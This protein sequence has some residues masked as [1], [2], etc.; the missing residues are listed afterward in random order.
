MNKATY[1][2]DPGILYDM[3]FSLKLRFNGERA[4]LPLRTGSLTYEE[5]EKFYRKI[6]NR[7]SDISDSLFPFFYYDNENDIKTAMFSY[8]HDY[9]DLT[10]DR[11]METF[12]ESLRDV[13]RLKRVVYQNYISPQCP[14]RF[15][16]SSLSAVKK[17][18]FSSSL[19]DHFKIHLY[20]FLIFGEDRIE[21]IIDSL[22][23]VEQLCMEYH[24][25]HEKELQYYSE[26]F[27]NE[28]IKILS[29]RFD[30]DITCFEKV[31][32]SFCSV[33]INGCQYVTYDN[34]WLNLVGSHILPNLYD[35]IFNVP[36]DLFQLGTILSDTQRLKILDMLTKED[37]YCA[38]I[39]RKLGIKNNSTLYH[40]FMMENEGILTAEKKSNSKKRIYYSINRRYIR[41][42][43]KILDDTF[44]G[45]K[46]NGKN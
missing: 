18:I 35:S 32:F 46:S 14:E 8:V 34:N 5:D 23:V 44:T 27:G 39:A 25:R 15:D 21:E 45:D 16:K 19:P 20:D 36:V 40:L 9:I 13:E 43:K 12:Y 7:L 42:L 33:M 1:L 24:A 29:D 17:D 38:E 3:L 11:L 2:K 6:I 22:R 37:M 26:N 41:S 4:Y 10:A 30:Y 28:Q 31:C